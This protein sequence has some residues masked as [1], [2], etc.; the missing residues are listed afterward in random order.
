MLILENFKKSL[1]LDQATR[2]D[3]VNDPELYCR[4]FLKDQQRKGPKQRNQIYFSL[5]RQ[6]KK[7]HK[8]SEVTSKEL[9]PL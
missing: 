5:R 6:R 9:V 3:Y 8:R 2:V 7:I 4:T 1:K